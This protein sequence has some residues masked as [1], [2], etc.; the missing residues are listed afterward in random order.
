M[1]SPLLLSLA[2]GC[3]WLFSPEALV[4]TGNAA[5]QLGWL[6]IPLLALLAL[7]FTVC[8]QTINSSRRSFADSSELS[9]LQQSI[10]KIP[11]AS[12]TLASCFPL[13]VLAATALLVTS[14]Y[15]FNEVFLYWF[16]NFG[17]A[18]MLLALLT[19]AQFLP[20]KYLHRLQF[21]FVSLAATGICILG[22]YGSVTPAK[23]LAEIL[24]QPQQLSAT[25]LSSALLL[26]LFAGSN[27][28][29]EKESRFSPVPLIAVL[30][31]MFWIFASLAHVDA[32]R[33]ASSTI[34]YMTASRKILGDTGRQIMGLVVISGSCAAVTGLMLL[35]R[36]KITDLASQQLA[37]QFLATRGQ[38]WLLP[39]L[40]AITT[41]S[42]MATG[43]AGDELLEI[44]LK[45][46]L[47][48][49]L[50]YYCCLS[51]SATFLLKN[52][53]QTL[54][55]PALLAPLLLLA[56]WLIIISSSPHTTEI[57][58]FISSSLVASTCLA[59]FWFFSNPRKKDTP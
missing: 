4:I 9:I 28:F 51:L 13:L 22:I 43:L 27:L 5:G 52:K 41:G 34:P 29:Q 55:L 46:A 30:V 56:G 11:A 23:P 59:A 20:I 24:Q 53:L 37:P 38:R 33:L 31:F 44:L 15:T 39:P 48:L 49:W 19:C 54:P 8:R 25:T 42:C 10:G 36:E 57:L 1:R 32:E 12:L 18:F 58:I 50:L 3:G 45:S 35:C 16:P 2:L 40:V 21:C 17:F 14:G 7:L 47:L 26:L 6:T